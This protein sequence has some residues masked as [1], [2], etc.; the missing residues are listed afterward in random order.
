MAAATPPRDA[1]ETL[2]KP[3]PRCGSRW[4]MTAIEGRKRYGC[5]ACLFMWWSL[6][7]IEAQ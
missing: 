7:K 1:I 3:C 4:N 2:A 5:F 6:R